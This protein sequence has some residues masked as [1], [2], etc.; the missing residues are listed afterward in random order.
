MNEEND[1]YS[2]EE[3]YCPICGNEM[4][5][6]TWREPREYMGRI[7]YERCAVLVCEECGYRAE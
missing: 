6:D 7:V 3:W 1:M 5:W 4:H 2:E